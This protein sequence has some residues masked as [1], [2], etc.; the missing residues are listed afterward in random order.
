MGG[1][2]G[3]WGWRKAR[4]TVRTE[5]VSSTTMPAKKKG[6]R[7]DTLQLARGTQHRHGGTTAGS[8]AATGQ[9]SASS[10]SHR[11]PVPQRPLVPLLSQCSLSFNHPRV[12]QG[13]SFEL[14]YRVK[15]A[16][17]GYRVKHANCPACVITM[18][19]SFS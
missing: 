7:A 8:S 12:S 2:G 16:R 4:P 6:A 14:I 3:V 10:G 11:K 1:Q 5:R 13:Q 18:R 9:R 19:K 15:C 17:K